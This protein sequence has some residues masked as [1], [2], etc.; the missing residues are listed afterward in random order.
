MLDAD[1][2]SRALGA[3]DA[4]FDGLFF[5]GITSTGVY[6]RPV[7]PARVAYA[8]RRRFFESPAAAEVAGFRPCLRCRPELAPGCAIIDAIPRLAHVAARRIAAGALNGGSVT[9]L[10]RD[11]GVSERHLR[12]ALEREV[13]VSPVELAQTHRL[14]LA[15]RLL[16]DTTLSVT[17]IAY[18][19]GFQSL[20]RFNAVFHERYRMSPSALRRRPRSSRT[21]ARASS[22]DGNAPLRLTLAYRA[23]LAWTVLLD[24]LRRDALP[25]VETTHANSYARTVRLGARTGVVVVRPATPKRQQRSQANLTVDV[26]PS[27]LP[28][29]M[30]L[31]ARLRHLFDLDAEPTVIDSHL[32]QGGLGAFVAAHPGLRLPGAFDGFEV[33]LAM[34]LSELPASPAEPNA[35]ARRVIEALGTPVDTGWDALTHVPPSAADVAQAGASALVRLGVDSVRAE[36]IVAIARMSVDRVVELEPGSDAEAV[37]RTLRSIP[38]IDAGLATRIVVRALQWP[39]AFLAT[40][41]ALQRAAGASSTEALLA[42]AQRWRPWRAYAAVHLGIPTDNAREDAVA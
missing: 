34:L 13:G 10:A 29:L 39:D 41:V 37:H 26:S 23:P 8:D 17:R 3:R 38:G 22:E 11:L 15:K 9:D 6:C 19:S 30:P 16:A 14:L 12:R 2:C 25:G 1:I 7:C 33:A 20:R 21:S 35:V 31:L 5:V 24:A 28:E 18:A 27:L 4:R 40:D 32:E 36:A 42:R